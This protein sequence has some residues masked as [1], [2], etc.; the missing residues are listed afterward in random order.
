ME[1]LPKM[2]LSGIVTALATPFLAD[3]SLDRAGWKWLLERQLAGG[4]QGVVVAG[5]TG[6]AA[7]LEEDEYDALL[8]AALER[9]ERHVPVLAGTG[10]SGTANT[11]RQTRRA[12]DLGADYALVVT[13]PYVR[14]TQAGLRA[15]YLE[16]AEHGGLPVVLYNV[17][18]RTGCDM[19]PDT[20]AALSEHPNIVAIKEANT[21]PARM[22]ALLQLC[23][24]GFAVFSGDDGSAAR[25]MLAGADGL[26]SVGSN[27]LP[28]TFRRLCDAARGGDAAAT[29][30]LDGALRAFHVFCG[31]ESNPIPIKALLAL[32]GIGQALRLP[33]QTLASVHHAQAERLAADAAALEEQSS[34]L[35]QAA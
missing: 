8:V 18:G 29:Q 13:P 24:E 20:V 21:D 11:V 2:A 25:A 33:L 28:A 14:P 9:I 19:S 30:S 32:G 15:H 17:P 22:Q 10:E 6:E 23:G 31:I 35:L 3:G 7:T 16:V 4:V 26:I 5:S 34:R 27:V 1:S 12:A